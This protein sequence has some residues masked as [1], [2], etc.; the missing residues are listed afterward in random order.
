MYTVEFKELF[1][2]T[3]MLVSNDLSTLACNI[4]RKDNN[5]P[6]GILLYTFRNHQIKLLTN[7]KLTAYEKDIVDGYLMDIQ[8]SSWLE[9]AFM[10]I[11]DQYREA[12][13]PCM[14][15]AFRIAKNFTFPITMQTGTEY[16]NCLTPKEAVL[17]WYSDPLN[18]PEVTTFEQHIDLVDELKRYI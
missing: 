11:S 6:I 5:K 14:K 12:P 3:F 9:S 4:C 17:N 1:F 8:P 13:E 2:F 18:N 16:V 7:S 15:D 10:A